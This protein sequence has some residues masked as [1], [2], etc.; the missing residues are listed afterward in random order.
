VYAIWHLPIFLNGGGERRMTTTQAG[1]AALEKPCA[2]DILA[3]F[4]L[5]QFHDK[6]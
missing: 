6:S 3:P 5:S 2:S 1:M 4:R